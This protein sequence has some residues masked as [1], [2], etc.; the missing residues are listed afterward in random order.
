M[1]WNSWKWSELDRCPWAWGSPAPRLRGQTPGPYGSYH[2]LDRVVAIRS[3]RRMPDSEELARRFLQGVA[4]LNRVQH[5]HV[6]SIFDRFEY[7]DRTYL[8]MEYIDG[9]TLEA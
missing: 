4:V 6:V 2:S 3:S 5:P 7:K 8:V 1:A 9:G